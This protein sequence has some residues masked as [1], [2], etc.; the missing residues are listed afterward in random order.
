MIQSVH[1][2]RAGGEDFAA[3][4]FVD[5][6]LH[7]GGR[8]AS[9]VRGLLAL[10]ESW[11]AEIDGTVAGFAVASRNFFAKPFVDLLVVGEDHR[12]LGVGS[13]LM[14][15]CEAV[16]DDDRLFTSTNQSN[17]PM[18][19]LL[20]KIGFEES[21]VIHNLDPGDPELVFVKFRRPG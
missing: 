16:H 14:N 17:A 6:L 18:R 19:A 3:M 5:P 12:R 15:H 13:A 7:G 21:G 20:A 11:V 4:A 1:I 10:G 9:V 8:R 2:R